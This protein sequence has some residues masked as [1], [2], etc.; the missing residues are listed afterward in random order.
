MVSVERIVEFGAIE[1]EAPL[2]TDLDQ[3]LQ[4]KDW[5][6]T[7][8]SITVN[9]LT[10]RYRKNLLPALDGISF[11]IMAGQRVGIVGRTGSGKSTLVQ[12]F[13][14][15]LEAESGLIEIGGTDISLIG[16]HKL[17]TSIAVIPQLPVL[18]SGSTIRENLDPFL[19]YSESKLYDALEAVQLKTVIDAL[20]AKL[21][22]LVADGGSNFSVGQRQLLCLA[23]ALLLN[24][25]IIILDEPTA[26]VDSNTDYL[27]QNTLRDRFSGAT[28]ISVAHRLDT[29][30]AYDR[31][32]VLGH[33]KLLEFGTPSELLSRDE[34]H[35]SLMVESTGEAMARY[36]RNKVNG[37]TQNC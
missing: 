25:Q 26:N 19:K 4:A 8:T 15:I 35:F 34:G 37:T 23:R 27:L 36:L 31:I 24:N 3:N 13:L 5:P 10:V 1:S 32:A 22:S 33:G 2:N 11:Q 21:D 9:D 12:A 28:I 30:I 6:K 16:L 20:P 18:F 29:I 17:R 14:R 7:D